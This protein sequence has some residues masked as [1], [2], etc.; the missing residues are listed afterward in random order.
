MDCRPRVTCCQARGELAARYLW[1]LNISPGLTSVRSE[2][3]TH[4]DNPGSAEEYEVWVSTRGKV[5]RIITQPL[6]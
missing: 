6:C 5:L 3:R 1:R 2:D 4:G